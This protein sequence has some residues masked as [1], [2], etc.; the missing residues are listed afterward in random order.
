MMSIQAK[1]PQSDPLRVLIVEDSEN[2]AALLLEELD[3]GGFAV[4]HRRVDDRVGMLDALQSA[5]WDVIISDY[6][7]PG[8]GEIEALEIYKNSGWD[9]PFI[10]VS[11]T[12]GEDVAVEC[13]KAGAHDYLMKNRLSRLPEAIRRELRESEDRQRHR[14]SAEMLTVVFNSAADGILLADA[15]TRRFVRA[16]DAMCRMLGYTHEEIVN[17]SVDD[18]HPAADLPKVIAIFNRQMRSEGSMAE[19]IPVKRKNGSIFLAAINAGPLELRGRTHLLSMFRDITE[20]AKMEQQ[21]KLAMQVLAAL[22]RQNDVALLV[23]DILQIIHK[24]I[25]IEAVAIR[26]HEGDDYPYYETKGFPGEFIEAERHLCEHNQTGEVVKDCEGN[27]V[28]ECMCGNVICG[29]FDPSKPFFTEQ[30]SFWTNCTTELLAS[31]TEEDRQSRT[32]NRCNG[33]GYES[34]AL[35]P[36]RSGDKVIGLVQLNDHRKDMFTLDMIRFFEGLGASIGIALGRKRLEENRV[37]MEAQLRQSQKLESIGTLASGVAHEINNP[38]MG[39]MNYAQLILDKLGPDSPVSGY[40]AE[41]GKET[42]R[43]ATIVK[44]LLDFARHKKQSHS[45]AHICDIVETTL[46]LISAVMRHDQITLEVVVPA[47]LPPIKCRSQQIQQVIMNLLTNARDALNE[48][49]P[50]YD[51]NKRIS[52]SATEMEMSLVN[53]HLSLRE[54]DPC[55]MTNDAA[56]PQLTNDTNRRVRAIRL[57]VEDPGSGISEVA[58]EHMFDPFFTTKKPDKGTGLG[59]SIS[60]GIVKDHHGELSVESEVGQWTRFHVDL[61]VDNGWTVAGM[62]I[63]DLMSSG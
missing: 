29:R 56:Q 26:L 4:K 46:S 17:L 34:V 50:G 6:S 22:N 11:G 28:L 37:T 40:A 57:T 38:I 7:M 45:P 55:P 21:Q 39:I 27:P 53:G 33:E 25:G 44:N 10:L 58:R 36:L 5:E 14:E 32:R 59:L 61:P 9:M 3:R 60:H 47:G 52:I 62:G 15:E 41:I 63:A 35:I 48:K 18:I 12:I 30:G 24:S 2:D 49:Y 31:T 51:E 16:N 43:V 13:M 8:F 1:N 23:K 54:N 19:D 42:E 20:R